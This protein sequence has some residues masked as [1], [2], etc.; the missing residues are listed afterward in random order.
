VAVIT[1]AAAR[2]ELPAEEVTV[3]LKMVLA[4]EGIT[5]RQ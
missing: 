3:A 4:I 1:A 2:G 5:C